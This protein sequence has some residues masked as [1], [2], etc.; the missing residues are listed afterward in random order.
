MES[1]VNSVQ[2]VSKTSRPALV[3]VELS[4]INTL[5]CK[6]AVLISYLLGNTWYHHG[7]T[8][9]LHLFR[10]VR[11]KAAHKGVFLGLTIDERIDIDIAIISLKAYIQSFNV[12]MMVHGDC[13]EFSF[14]YRKLRKVYSSV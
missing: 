3:F 14:T 9:S 5:E 7:L 10:P 8:F 2:F 1:F 12:S 6:K 11:R 4:D 13:T